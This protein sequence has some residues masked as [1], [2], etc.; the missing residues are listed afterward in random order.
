MALTLQACMRLAHEI[1]CR[2]AR[3][4]ARTLSTVAGP[5]LVPMRPARVD[6]VLVLGLG[7]LWLRGARRPGWQRRQLLDLDLVAPQQ[8][9]NHLGVLAQRASLQVPLQPAQVHVVPV[10]GPAADL[11]LPALR[12][13]VPEQRIAQLQ[14]R[15]EGRGP[16]GHGLITRRPPAL[17]PRL[18]K[19]RA[20]VAQRLA[21]LL[22]LQGDLARALAE[23]AALLLL[24]LQLAQ[25]RAVARD[26]GP[27]HAQ[28]PALPGLRGGRGGCRVA[29]LQ[30][31]AEAGGEGGATRCLPRGCGRCIR[32]ALLAAD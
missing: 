3:A 17:A 9:R 15:Q 6:A 7:R 22:Q 14:E 24:L 13:A 29:L 5:A 23:R 11:E 31:P 32:G 27:V 25:P 26:A 21:Q 8:L 28:L 18:N 30:E 19:R 10:D 2:A 12:L 20:K 16:L 1:A 4:A